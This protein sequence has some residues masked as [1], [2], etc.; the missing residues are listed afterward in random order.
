MLNGGGQKVNKEFYDLVYDAW[1]S[2][3]NPDLVSKDKYDD[4]LAQGYYPDEITLDMVLP[5]GQRARDAMQG[6]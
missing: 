2:G 4:L 3:K 5:R 6:E 1:M